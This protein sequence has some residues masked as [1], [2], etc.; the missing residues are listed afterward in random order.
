MNGD[1]PLATGGPTL[2][3]ALRDA[4]KLADR[5][6]ADARLADLRAAAADRPTLRATLDRREVGAVLGA[7]AD[8]SAY[9]WQLVTTDPDR[10]QALL[11]A[12]PDV[13]LERALD[14]MLAGIDA[15]GTPSEAMT[16]LR[17][18]KG[19]VALL[20]A[21]ADLGGCW[22]FEPVVGALTRFADAAVSGTIDFLLREAVRA[23][24]LR[25]GPDVRV[26]SGLA[27][28]ALG[29]G[30]GREL[31][32]SSDIDLVVLYDSQAARLSPD[33]APAPFYVRLTQQMVRMLGERTAEGYVLRVDLRLRPDPASTAV[34]I[35]LPAAF[36]YY[37]ALGQNWE[38]AAYIKARPIAG[39]I[40]LGTAVL[41]ELSGF[42][43]RKYF[44]YA[45]IADIHAMKR[46]IHAVR[47]HADVV[48][49][50][51]DLKLGRGGI[52]EIEFFVQTQQLIFGG[53]RPRLRGPRTLDMLAELAADGWVSAEAMAD[54]SAA[55]RFLRRIEHRLQMLADEQTQRLPKDAA[56]LERVARWSGYDGYDAFAAE[57]MRQMRAV[58]RHYARLF[59][60]APSLD[61]EAGSLVF[62]GA[63]IDPETIETLA[64]LGFSRAA[65]AVETIRGWHFG[66]RAAVRSPRAREVLTDLVPALLLSFAGSGDPDQALRA[67]DA[68]LARL[69]AA[70]ELFA[71][72]KSNTALRDLFADILGLAPRLAASVARRPHLLDGA[73]DPALLRGGGGDVGA[74]MAGLDPALARE[75]FLDRVRD[76]A[77]EEMFLIG[78]RLLAGTDAPQRTGEAHADLA[79][80]I[81]RATL[82]ETETDFSRD[83]GTVPGASCVIVALGRLGS[84]EMT[85]ASDLDLLLIYDVDPAQP[86]STGPRRLDPT[87]YY[88]RLTQRLIAS[89]TVT[90]RRG[91]LYDVDMRLRPSGNQG[92]LATRLRSFLDYQSSGADLWEHMALTRARVIAGDPALGARVEAAIDA[93]L[94]LPRP[95]AIGRAI[96][97]LRALVA[98]EKGERDA[99]DLKLV[100]GGVL[101][102]DFVAQ[103]LALRHAAHHPE[104]LLRSTP[105]IV[106]KAREA[107]L[108]PA[109]LADD[110]VEAY[111][112]YADVLQITRLTVEGLFDPARAGAGLIRRLVAA[113]GLP[114]LA[115]LERELGE[116]RAMVRRAFTSVLT[117]AT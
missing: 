72:L 100:A 16:Y 41:A 78:V 46:Q 47:G 56:A 115:T 19:R 69:P 18:G 96:L 61:V 9:L 2:A 35:S 24:K 3:D 8:H 42:V 74:R 20:V 17:A 55:Y 80:A 71:I 43:W 51:H 89:L 12:P 15:A 84:R 97:D 109:G 102:I 27:V 53:R 39:D 30:G 77:Q 59:E 114:D 5:A 103:F 36:S 31:N 37:E 93:T 32:Y 7:I 76:L 6:R 40:D 81:V 94:R 99:W 23:G 116:R 92:P 11:G 106:S 112:L 70:V 10:L 113:A 13:T 108:L 88:S 105:A 58:E 107:G 33:V 101:D 64:A 25:P 44:D 111:R 1:E 87:R 48:V 104:L 60:H 65:E 98:K 45:A 50:G 29:K 79:A 52:R 91:R 85:A 21:L 54:L 82:A 83:H 95:D 14:T 90:T 67:F 73:I 63:T 75:E 49:P 22:G 68:L 57:A 117:G 4:P 86:D 28:L 110:L 66:R 26:G 38:R 34:A 62:A